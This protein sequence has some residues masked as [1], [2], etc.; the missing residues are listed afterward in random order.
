MELPFKIFSKTNILIPAQVTG[1][2][3]TYPAQRSQQGK[4]VPEQQF[5]LK[6]ADSLSEGHI[7]Q[8]SYSSG[9]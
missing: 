5:T 9:G 1:G 6:L 8:V 7:S 3:K 2:L 4:K